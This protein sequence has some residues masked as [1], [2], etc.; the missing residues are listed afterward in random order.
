MFSRPALDS[1][2]LMAPQRE[3]HAQDTNSVEV[4]QVYERML[5]GASVR[6]RDVGVGAGGRVHLLEAGS[7]SPV[8]LLHG[9]GDAAGIFLPLLNELQGVRAL[10]PDLPGRGLSAPIDL[11]RHRY[12]ET[13]VAWLDHLL[14]AL[15]L[16]G[17]TLVG[18]SGG[19]LWALWYA[20][21]HP[22][23]VNRLV[24]IG[25]P[26]LPNTRCPLPHRLMAMPGLGDVLSRLVPPSPKSLLQFANFM[27]E[28]ETLARHPA[29][30]DLLVAGRQNAVASRVAKAEFRL[31]ISPFALLSPSGF[32]RRTRVRPDQLRQVAMPTLV[33]W[34]DHDPLGG[35]LVAQAVTDLIPH[36]RLAVLPAGHAPWLGHP[37]QT[38]ALIADFMQ[39]PRKLAGSTAL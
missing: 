26:T 32:R 17:T 16:D 9:T 38:A 6:G 12:R 33:V 15:E 10:A 39:D 25:V 8:L 19:G 37:R 4:R 13:A 34:G 35:V 29:L 3:S 22:D 20:L 11:P 27:G 21:T 28:K 36:A 1:V 23:R 5:A 7:G 31:L 2:S 24:L 18:H 14:D 30:I